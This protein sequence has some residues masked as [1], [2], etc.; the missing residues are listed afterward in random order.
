MK[1]SEIESKYPNIPNYDTLKMLYDEFSLKNRKAVINTTDILAQIPY[2]RHIS[3]IITSDNKNDLYPTPQ[4]CV[5]R[6]SVAAVGPGPLF[7]TK[8][9][10]SF[11]FF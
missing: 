2:G 10:S 8:L 6:I 9:E 4:E 1:A 11:S 5:T 3:E 7:T